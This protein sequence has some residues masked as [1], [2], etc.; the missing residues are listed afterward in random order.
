MQDNTKPWYRSTSVLGLIMA[1]TLYALRTLGVI[2]VDDPSIL[3][4]ACQG[5]EFAG[6]VL[7]VIGR[8]RARTRLTLGFSGAERRRVCADG[9]CDDAGQPATFDLPSGGGDGPDGNVPQRSAG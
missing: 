8:V 4:A 2:E 3:K 1:I 9:R 7:G 5:G 6:I